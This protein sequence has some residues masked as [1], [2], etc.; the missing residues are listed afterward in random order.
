MQVPPLAYRRAPPEA[1][2]CAT[3]TT[4]PTGGFACARSNTY[5]STPDRSLDRCHGG[6]ASFRGYLLAGRRPINTGGKAA[7]RLHAAT[8][9][10][11]C[12]PLLSRPRWQQY[13]VRVLMSPRLAHRPGRSVDE[14]G[15]E[16]ARHYALRLTLPDH[17][18]RRAKHY[19]G[20]VAKHCRLHCA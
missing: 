19:L 6:T 1:G 13:Y 14:V 11:L 3:A 18:C 12:S 16:L 4:T 17:R 20:T 8:E 15:R 2:P 7:V 5:R 10:A 9:R